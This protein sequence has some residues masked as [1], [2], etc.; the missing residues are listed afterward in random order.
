[1]YYYLYDSRLNDK[2]YN[3]VIAKIETRLTDLG[4]NGKINRLSF[5]KNIN[6]KYKRFF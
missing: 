2:K 5:L 3:N 1:M 6:Q 4:I